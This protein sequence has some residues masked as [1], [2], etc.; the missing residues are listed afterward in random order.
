MADPTLGLSDRDQELRKWSA[1]YRFQEFPK[2]LY[3]FNPGPGGKLVREECGVGSR[4]EQAIKEG[5]GWR[6]TQQDAYDLAEHAQEDVGTAAAERAFHDRRMS[7]AAQAEAAAVDAATAKHLGEI[8]EAHKRA[9][10]KK[11]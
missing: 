1:P 5:Q 4:D 8:P 11:E 7:P 10:R 6:E 9:P 3:R 2:M